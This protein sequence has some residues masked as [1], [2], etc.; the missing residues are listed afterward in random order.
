MRSG[1][2]TAQHSTAQL[3]GHLSMPL[4]VSPVCGERVPANPA[5]RY[6]MPLQHTLDAAQSDVPEAEVD[7]LVM[8]GMK[9]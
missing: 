3:T 4:S 7:F 6:A 9:R 8:R 2:S 5:G 1:D